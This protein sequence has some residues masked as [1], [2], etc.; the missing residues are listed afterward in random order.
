MNC[1]SDENDNYLLSIVI[2]IITVVKNIL[3]QAVSSLCETADSHN[4]VLTGCDPVG[5]LTPHF[6][7]V[8]V[9]MCTDPPPFRAVLLYMAC[10]P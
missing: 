9:Q 7:A 1:D 6:L 8:G 2:I 4:E 3:H 5:V 10:N